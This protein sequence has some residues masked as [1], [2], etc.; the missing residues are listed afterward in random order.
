[1]KEVLSIH[2]HPGTLHVHIQSSDLQE[3]NK[4]AGGANDNE[5]VWAGV[6]ASPPHLPLPPQSLGAGPNQGGCPQVVVCVHVGN[7][8]EGE[9]HQGLVAAQVRE[10]A[11]TAAA[12][13]TASTT[14]TECPVELPKSALPTV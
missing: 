3:P 10:P 14:A 11:T 5:R 2:K 1:M 12:T 4:E 7:G 9:I 6:W 13:A 8:D